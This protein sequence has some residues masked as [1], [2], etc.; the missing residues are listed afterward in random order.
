VYVEDPVRKLPDGV[1]DV[2]YRCVG[3]LSAKGTTRLQP[4]GN[5]RRQ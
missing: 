1:F 3:R 4:N 5:P 2:A